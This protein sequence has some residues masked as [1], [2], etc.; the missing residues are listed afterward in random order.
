MGSTLISPMI[1][2]IDEDNKGIDDSVTDG[3]DLGALDLNYTLEETVDSIIAAKTTTWIDEWL[4][5]GLEI[6]SDSYS[7]DL[8]DEEL[9]V[10][11]FDYS[12]GKCILK[13]VL[14]GGL[15]ASF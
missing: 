11:D 8:N 6:E 3:Y 12:P 14:T 15:I 1:A 13:L 7:V 5:E 10:P 4:N 9:S 2:N